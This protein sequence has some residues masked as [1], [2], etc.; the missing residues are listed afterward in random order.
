MLFLRNNAITDEESEGGVCSLGHFFFP[1][2][3]RV[4]AKDPGVFV[5]LSNAFQKYVN[6]VVIEVIEYLPIFSI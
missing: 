2:L 5:W 1:L 6:E 3:C 4:N